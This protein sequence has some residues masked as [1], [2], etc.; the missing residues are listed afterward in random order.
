MASQLDYS[1][2]NT[3]DSEMLE[4]SSAQENT[5]G[6]H[7]VLSMTP[8]KPTKS[9]IADSPEALLTLPGD[10]SNMSTNISSSEGLYLQSERNI[11]A[12]VRSISSL[13][14]GLIRSLYKKISILMKYIHLYIV[15]QN[16]LLVALLYLRLINA[17][18]ALVYFIISTF[19]YFF[20][21]IRLWC[22]RT[23]SNISEEAGS[24]SSGSVGDFDFPEEQQ[25]HNDILPSHHQMGAASQEQT[26][27]DIDGL[28]E[29]SDERLRNL[30][31]GLRILSAMGV[32]R[33]RRTSRRTVGAGGASRAIGREQSRRAAG[34]REIGLDVG[35]L[36]LQPIIDRFLRDSLQSH[37]AVRGGISQRGLNERQINNLYTYKYNR[38]IQ[39]MEDSTDDDGHEKQCIIC[40]EQ[41]ENDQE[42][43][44]LPCIHTYHKFCIDKWLRSHNSCPVCKNRVI[45]NI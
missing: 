1:E 3:S 42:V 9:P 4:R 29:F 24:G 34:E 23:P 17:R 27:L 22:L 38:K 40:F 39:E 21:K 45:D 13:L 37:G 32:S 10:D 30:Y 36:A 12:E 25:S 19:L 41:F 7:T 28:E 6:E 26:G 15:L 11:E 8:E 2:L 5:F 16:I 20:F 44:S 33:E 14:S 35:H 43:K 18:I 31:I